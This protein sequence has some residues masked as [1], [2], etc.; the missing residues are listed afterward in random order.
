MTQTRRR[1]VVHIALEKS[2]STT[3][4]ASLAAASDALLAQ[5]VAFPRFGGGKV[6]A[7]RAV[8]E[9][10]RGDGEARTQV[11][12]ILRNLAARGDVGTLVLSGETL[13]N[14]GPVALRALLDEAGWQD[15]PL[16]AL[17]IV[18]EPTG[19]L[20]SYYA[21]ATSLFRET[22]SFA[23]Y[24]KHALG[25]GTVAWDGV[26]APWIAAEDA[27]FVAVPLAA[28]DDERPVVARVLEAMGLDAGAVPEAAARNEA[29]DPRT[30][31][32]ARRLAAFQMP[33]RRGHR[34][35]VRQELFAAAAE[36]GF[37][38][39]FQGLDPRLAATIDEACRTS[40]D[41]FAAALWGR[42]WDAVY[43]MP[44]RGELVANAWPAGATPSD[45]AAIA[46]IVEEVSGA[47]GLKRKR[48]AGLTGWLR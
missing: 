27:D 4:Q 30:V 18:R 5:G 32:A 9:A 12:G 2:A 33:E 7:Q 13:S 40:N 43:R 17:A 23:A 19:W 37:T 16:T 34:L 42:P 14:F 35:K 15:V 29:V 8:A 26:F 1:I 25:K 38:G 45:E 11:L 41:R 10:L 3:L 20:N 24:V 22:R 47:A 36:A 21:F 39:R 28:R 44:A 48:F 31:E 6:K 46:R